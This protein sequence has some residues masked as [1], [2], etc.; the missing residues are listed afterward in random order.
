MGRSRPSL[1]RCAGQLTNACELSTQLCRSNGSSARLET[2]GLGGIVLDLP[3]VVEDVPEWHGRTHR[4]LMVRYW[5]LSC[6]GREATGMSLHD[7][8]RKSL[9]QYGCDATCN[10]PVPPDEGRF[11]AIHR[12][13]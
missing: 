1:T 9:N 2:W 12:I 7:P 8:N 3:E 11:R 10:S 4:E 5:G 13:S 6:R